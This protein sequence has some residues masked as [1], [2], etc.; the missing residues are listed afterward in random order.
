M[1]DDGRAACVEVMLNQSV[2]L[3]RDPAIRTSTPTW[4]DASLDVNP[5]AEGIRNAIKDQVDKF[6]N[7][8]L[9]VNPKR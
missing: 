7:A 2:R 3:Q 4:S 5:G 6:L 1:S 8:W 9:S